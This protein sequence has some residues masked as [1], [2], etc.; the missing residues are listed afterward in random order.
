ML[1]LLAERI[2]NVAL[3]FR[4]SEKEH[5]IKVQE[6]HGEKD[7]ESLLKSERDIMDNNGDS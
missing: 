7:S 2:K 6:L 1:C 5:F 4:T 3:D